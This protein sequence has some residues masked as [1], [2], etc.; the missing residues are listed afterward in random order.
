MVR[1]VIPMLVAASLLL[2]GCRS[3][4]WLII[5]NHTDAPVIVQ[6]AGSAWKFA[7]GDVGP[8]EYYPG[9]TTFQVY[10]DHCTKLIGEATIPATIFGPDPTWSVEADGQLHESANWGGD[11]AGGDLVPAAP[12]SQ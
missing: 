10:A 7:P 12:C 2:S 8:F 3:E 4:L 9:G 6:V 5:G 11:Y 1:R